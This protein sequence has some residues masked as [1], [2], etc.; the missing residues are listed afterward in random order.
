MSAG[1]QGV[2]E[3]FVHDIEHLKVHRRAGKPSLKKPMLLRVVLRQ[4][5]DGKLAENRIRFQQVA[6]EFEADY[7]AQ[8]GTAT[9]AAEPFFRLQ[10]A[11]FWILKLPEHSTAPGSVPPKAVLSRPD[12][13]A[14]LDADLWSALQHPD[15]LQRSMAAVQKWLE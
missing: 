1:H 11:P 7:L 8:T 15:A 5:R 6:D 2:L 13:Y 3:E 9:S 10:T 12:A 14:R 4:I